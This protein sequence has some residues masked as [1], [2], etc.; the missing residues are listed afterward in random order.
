MDNKLLIKVCGITTK[1]QALALKSL[2]VDLI[3]MIHHSTS[4]R[5]L[6]NNY[7]DN[8]DN[9]ILVTVN[10]NEASLKALALKFN[11]KRLQLHGNETPDLCNTLQS[12]GL[13]I[14]KAFSIHDNFNFEECNPYVNATDYFLFDTKGTY[15]G[16]NGTKFNWQKLDK[17]Q[18]DKPFFL[19]GGIDIED[20][21]MIKKITHPMLAGIDINSQFETSPGIKDLNKV[22]A[23]I[24]QLRQ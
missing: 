1:E 14:F 24:N 12:D 2:K 18:L 19:S 7:T 20:V 17:Y 15:K 4:P 23:F 11:T 22:T 6:E 9:N 16:G 10:Q 8:L 5:H 13:E 3:G 21:E